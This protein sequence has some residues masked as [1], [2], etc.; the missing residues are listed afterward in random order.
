MSKKLFKKMSIC[1]QCDTL[2]IKPGSSLSTSSNVLSLE[3]YGVPL[4]TKVVF[5][6]GISKLAYQ[7]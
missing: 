7:L 6:Y 4:P 3:I 2:A 1:I 5:E